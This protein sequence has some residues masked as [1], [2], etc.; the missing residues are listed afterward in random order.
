MQLL[1][2]LL[3]DLFALA[4]VLLVL[5]IATVFA[6]LTLLG[7]LFNVLA[8]ISLFL[9]WT[10]V[11]YWRVLARLHVAIGYGLLAGV[12][13]AAGVMLLYERVAWLGALYP[14]SPEAVALSV[15]VV[16]LVVAFQDS[17]RELSTSNL[18]GQV[19]NISLL[20]AIVVYGICNPTSPLLRMQPVGPPPL[21]LW[22]IIGCVPLIWL[23]YVMLV[24]PVIEMIEYGV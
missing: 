7:V 19:L 18:I 9:F 16:T 23:A 1:M 13:A 3:G 14:V 17:T 12:C 6:S 4:C 8:V 22:I 15:T 5:I 10:V 20:E 11:K 21:W 2:R 24:K